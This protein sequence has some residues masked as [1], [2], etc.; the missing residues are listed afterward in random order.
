MSDINQPKQK[1]SRKVQPINQKQST[2]QILGRPRKNEI[3]SDLMGELLAIMVKRGDNIR[4]RVYRR[5]QE[6]ILVIPNDIYEPADLAGKPGIG[7][8]ILEKLKAYDE[9]GTLDIL[10]KEK[11]NPE[12]IL[13]DVYGVG[14]KKAKELVAKGITSIAQLRE[15]QN[16][17][18]NDVQK[19]GL[20]YYED[21]QEKIP[22]KEIDEYAGVFQSAYDT[23]NR[24][25]EMKYEIVGSYR[26][27]ATASGDIDVIITAKDSTAFSK[28][29]D[30]LLGTKIIIEVLSRGK[31]KCLVITRLKDG[32]LSRRVDFLYTTPEEYPFAVL[33]FTGSK[34]FNATMRGFALTKGLSL[35]EHGLSK[36]VDKKK[37][38]KLSLNIVDERGIFDYL[39][40]V[41]KEPNERIDGRA[42]V[43]KY[44]KDEA[45]P[46]IENVGEPV[47]EKESAQKTVE[48]NVPKSSVK[49]MNSSPK[50]PKKT[51]KNLPKGFPKSTK[52]FPKDPKEIESF[53]TDFLKQK[54]EEK[55]EDR[56]EQGPKMPK[57][58]AEQNPDL[59]KETI[60]ELPKYSGELKPILQKETSKEVPKV[61]TT[62]K[63]RKS[64]PQKVSKE[65]IIIEPKTPKLQTQKVS[66]EPIIIEPKT[67]KLEKP[68]VIEIPGSPKSP[69]SSIEKQQ[70]PIIIPKSS[71]SKKPRKTKTEKVPK[72]PKEPKVRT[73]KTQ[74]NK[75]EKV[76]KVLKEPKVRTQKNKPPKSSPK[77]SK[78]IEVLKGSPK[79][80]K[81]ANIEIKTPEEPIAKIEYNKLDSAKDVPK[82]PKI[83]KPRKNT[84]KKLSKGSPKDPK[85]PENIKQKTP[86]GE[87]SPKYSITQK[88]KSIS[89]PGSKKSV[90]KQKA[91]DIKVSQ[92]PIETMPKELV[93]TAKS[94]IQD[95]KNTGITVLEKLSQEELTTL[96]QVANAN[97]YNEK[98]GLMTDNEYDIVKE[99]MEKKYPTN[100]VIQQVGA[101]IA[102]NKVELPYEMWSMDKIKPDSKALAGWV[103]KY[104]G[105]YVLS[106]KLDGVSGLYSTEG[107]IPKL[108]TRGDGKVGQDVSFLLPI[109]K[110]PLEKGI[111]VRGEFIIPKKVFAEKYAKQFANPR[112]LVS[113]IVSSKKAD[114]KTADLHFVAYEVIMPQLKPRE[115]LAKLKTSGFEVVQNETRATLSNESL[116]ETLVDWRT[117]YEY[118]IDGVIVTDDAIH[119]RIS[120]NPE[121]AF[122][123]KMVLSDQKAEVKVVD[124]LWSPSK[125]GFLKPRV[126][127][128][129]V[130]LGGVTIEYATGYNAKFIEDNMIGIGAIVE[131][132]RS[133]DVIPKILKVVVPAEKAK[134]P[135][136]SYKWN[137]TRVDVLLENAGENAT[138][139]EKNLTAFFSHLEVDGLKAG[140]IKKLMAAGYETIPKIL[141]MTKEDFAKLGYKTMAD[142]YVE[143]IKEKVENASVVDLMVASGTMGRGLSNKK[144]E[145]ILE[146]HPDILVSKDDQAAKIAKVKAIKGIEIKTATLFV[147]NIPRFI[148][149]LESI[150]QTKKLAQP[151]SAKTVIAPES[152]VDKSNPLYGKKIVMTK[153]RDQDIIRELKSLGA[154]LSDNIDKNTF[155]LIVKSLEDSSNKT[156]YAVE[157]GIPIMTPEDF[158]AKYLV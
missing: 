123:F 96:L 15:R 69:K 102:R 152:D 84:T 57:Y 18:L 66:K 64:K 81:P 142:K 50:P 21:I 27:G 3:Y 36:M 16:E 113:G 54:G 85:I 1:Q 60:G 147:E 114:E 72:V 137:D 8:V 38:E 32:Y 82:E 63:T 74:K 20:K 33:Y 83:K 14:P 67:P 116:S 128:E 131:I 121:H 110:L 115:Q 31:S 30:E 133:G 91:T 148:E 103:R 45:V 71:I 146:A 17:V 117:N 42:V 11:E 124:V 53:C 99:Y 132:I 134:M 28:W 47:V 55:S 138:V 12:N 108:F 100:A 98:G 93:E 95:F 68:E 112:N 154:I 135:V 22:R 125:D 48:K 61:P 29:I 23:V 120:G 97:Y 150:G 153:V 4:A 144:I 52:V 156:K 126:R 119:P 73:P 158:K 136:E 87:T 43:S 75:T 92:Q 39:G 149:F 62:K 77:E 106:C 35:N 79:E 59:Q 151:G 2:E 145:P 80:S 129:P 94:H 24:Q 6:S 41:Y 51:R 157:H 13:S 88:P 155:V 109:L 10:E 37:E 105:P 143:N 58:S 127:I 49:E 90:E 7:P 141:D 65:P 130:S 139:Q 44:G 86:E 46:V 70:Q 19:V 26:R 107:D 104:P 89:K 140:N 40:L 34:G 56:K 101:P 122:A 9:T 118:E 78:T 111:V 5:A 76:P 25:T